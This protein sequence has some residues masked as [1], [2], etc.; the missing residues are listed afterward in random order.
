M[1]ASDKE[2]EEVADAACIHDPITTRFPKVGWQH[3]V[4]MR[5]QQC[6]L[7][8]PTVLICQ[9]HLAAARVAAQCAI[10]SCCLLPAY[11]TP[12]PHAF[13][14]YLG[15]SVLSKHQQVNSCRVQ[16]AGNSCPAVHCNMMLQ[17]W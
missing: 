13:P 15:P 4:L 14:R 7:A 2:I 16:Q 8:L 12:S 5:K 17:G 6:T 9:Q 1:A 10:L 11:T 3:I